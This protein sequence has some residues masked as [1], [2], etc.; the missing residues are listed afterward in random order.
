MLLFFGTTAYAADMAYL[1]TFDGSTILLYIDGSLAGSKATTLNTSAGYNH[2]G[3]GV[4]TWW[5]GSYHWLCNGKV[6]EV[7]LYDYALSS[8]QVSELFG[9]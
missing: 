7:K 8:S 3:I 6:D 1:A 4:D 9:L 2:V 5:N